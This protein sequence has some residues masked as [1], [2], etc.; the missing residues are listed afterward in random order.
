M[1]NLLSLTTFIPLLGAGILALFL[2][3]DDAAAQRNAKW[4]ALATTVFTF[5][6][7]LFILAGFKT[8]AAGFQFVED[9]QWLL[10]M[11]YKMGVDGISLLFVMLTTF[12]MPLVIAACWDVTHRVK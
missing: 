9:R 2:R 1:G 8:D 4:V 5:A 7:S 11:R 10:G 12:L 6:V 3:G